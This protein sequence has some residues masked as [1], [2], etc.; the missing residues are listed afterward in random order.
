[1]FTFECRQLP[2]GPNGYP[3]A[4]EQSLN[5]QGALNAQVTTAYPSSCGAATGPGGE[6]FSFAAYF[7]SQG[8]WY[9]I[10][11]E[12]DYVS[13]QYKRPGTYTVQAAIYSFRAETSSG[14]VL[15]D[16]RA[17]VGPADPNYSGSVQLTVTGYRAGRWVGSVSGTLDW[18]GSTTEKAQV[19]ISGGWTC[20][21]GPMTGPG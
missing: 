21:P 3:P 2:P 16:P 12:T 15:M 9:L 13:R 5:F 14:I 1:M 10:K 18:T 11:F 19:N 6:L 4:A 20:T 17:L 7:Q 8:T